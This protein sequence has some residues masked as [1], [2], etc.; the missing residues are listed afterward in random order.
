MPGIPS[1][2]YRLLPD[3]A[4]ESSV[5]SPGYIICTED[6]AFT[7]ASSDCAGG[8]VKDS[9]NRYIVGGG[10]SF[11]APIFAGF[12]AILNQYE[13]TFGQGNVN[14]TLYGLAAQPSVYL[15]AF[16]D[17]TSGTTACSTGDGSCGAP[18]TVCLRV[19]RWL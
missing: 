10:T 19:H 7:S 18:G 16:H 1:G 12:V 14:P 5:A 8:S 2:S 3:I 11:A 4:I 9:N 15:S 6:K 13:H 17:I